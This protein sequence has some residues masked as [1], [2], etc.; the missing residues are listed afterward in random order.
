MGFDYANNEVALPATGAALFVDLDSSRVGMRTRVP[1]EALDVNG[2]IRVRSMPLFQPSGARYDVHAF[3]DGTFYTILTNP[4]PSVPMDPRRL[5]NPERVL[6][7]TPYKFTWERT[8]KADVGFLPGDVEK[9]ATELAAE[10]SE[11][12]PEGI[13][14]DKLSLYLLEIVKEQQKQI[15]ALQ[16]AVRA[17][18]QRASLE[19]SK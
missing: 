4:E 2:N 8:R 3:S 9:V 10:R 14:Y 11:Q 13:K 5:S 1:T 15:A 17:L 7:L 12:Y 16:A 18:E 19:R 6:E